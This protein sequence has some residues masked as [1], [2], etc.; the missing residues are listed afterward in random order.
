M[1]RLGAAVL[2]F[3]AVATPLSGQRSGLREA[4]SHGFGGIT[5]VVAEPLGDF[6]RN[7]NVAAGLTLFGVFP[8]DPGGTLGLRLD[9]AYLV[10]DTDYRGWGVSTTSQIGTLAAGPQATLGRGPVRI[11]GFATFGGSVFWTS[12]SYDGYCGCYDSDVFF[13]DGHTTSTRQVGTGLLLALS[14]RRTPIAIDLGLR[15]VR[16]ASVTYVPAG[17]FTDNGGGTYT[18]ERVT[19]PVHLRV[20]QVGVSIGR[21]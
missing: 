15:E 19:T 20:F 16:H 14:R 6:K 18:V 12:A 8:L 13:L 4:R 2:M 7:G 9:G 11:Y 21:R 17:G 5:L 1:R 10:Y 3:I